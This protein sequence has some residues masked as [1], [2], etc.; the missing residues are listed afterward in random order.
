M[1]RALWE[2]VR[3][4]QWAKN[5]FIFGAV[6]FDKKLFVPEHFFST[7]AAFVM[8]CLLSSAVYIINDVGDIEKD[9]QHP[10]KQNR[11]DV[12]NAAFILQRC[13]SEGIVY[14]LLRGTASP[15][16]LNNEIPQLRPL[17]AVRFP[18]KGVGEFFDKNIWRN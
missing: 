16:N 6:V 1:V 3:P 2:S 5:I 18:P 13:L 10:V 11:P 15:P 14:L 8:F 4:K 12:T 7:L 9:R 17:P